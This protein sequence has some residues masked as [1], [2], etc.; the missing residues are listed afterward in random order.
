MRQ[1]FYQT[2]FKAIS[3]HQFETSEVMHIFNIVMLFQSGDTFHKEDFHIYYLFVGQYLRTAIWPRWATL[4]R[5]R[6]YLRSYKLAESRWKFILLNSLISVAVV[7]SLSGIGTTCFLHV[8]VK[9][10]AT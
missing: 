4:S 5:L 1:F 6:L 3:K 2:E 8:C 10:S 7:I 9:D